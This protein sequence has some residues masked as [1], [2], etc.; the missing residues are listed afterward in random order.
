MYKKEKIII[1]GAGGIGKAAGLILAEKQEFDASIY[2][3]DINFEAAKQVCEWITAGTSSLIQVEP[4]FI[5]P[6]QTTEEMKFVFDSSDI[7]LDCLPGSEAPRMARFAREFGLHYVNLTEYV[8]E[9]EEVVQ[10]ATG[11]ETGFILQA[12][13]APGYINIL[14]K[15]LAEQF[16]KKYKT[17][18][19][20]EISMKVG[21]LTNITKSPHYYGFTWSPIGVATEY[22]KD[23][24]VVKN[25]IK[26]IIPSLSDTQSIIIDGIR[27]EDDFTSGGA[28]D[29]PEFFANKVNSLHYKTIRYPGHYDWVRTQIQE[30]G[31][32]ENLAI[33]LLAKMKENIPHV[34]DDL[35]VIYASVMAKDE[36]N[37]LHLLEKS[38]KIH[39]KQVG[40]YKLK[41][42]K[43]A[44]AAPLLECARLLLSGTYK[45]PILQS[46]IDT[47]EFLNG[48]FVQ[49]IYG[50]MSKS[51]K[52]LAD[53]HL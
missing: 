53:L 44:T 1:A 7:I 22:V 50:S 42:I 43:T 4:F 45:G 26:Q 40:S 8:K 13:L 28:A 48:P 14:A 24:I 2:I 6:K 21:A 20:E 9:S 10:I 5:D 30:L 35:I 17:D 37:E 19:F 38:M 12:G 23:A 29:M 41:A 33:P 25:G 36:K 51:E 15:Y 46:M 49:Y 27:Y 34:E 32:D 52:V 39:P 16:T 18:F 47:K 3:G 31:S 11:A